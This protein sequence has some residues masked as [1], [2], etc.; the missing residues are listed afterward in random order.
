[1]YE[2][3]T[4]INKWPAYVFSKL[5]CRFKAKW[6]AEECSKPRAV[7]ARTRTL[8][9]VGG[10]FGKPSFFPP[11][12]NAISHMLLLF[13]YCLASSVLVC[14]S[15]PFPGAT[16]SIISSWELTRARLVVF[17]DRRPAA[18]S[19]VC[20]RRM[21]RFVYIYILINE[22]RFKGAG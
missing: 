1:M 13:D 5:R 15:V 10:E 7:D 22:L 2:K 20:A 17:T 12:A 8:C 18:C 14:L 4:S 21:L 11:Q 3:N 6:R 16:Y 19:C 9:R